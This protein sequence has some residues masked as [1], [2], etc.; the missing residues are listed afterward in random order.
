MKIHGLCLVKNE[1]DVLQETL[2]SALH[3]CDHIYVF[4][5]GSNDGT[6]EL[7]KEHCQD[8]IGRLCH[9]CRM[10]SYIAMVSGLIFSMHFGRTLALK[11]G[12]A[13]W[14]QMNSILMTQE[15]FLLK[16]PDHFQTVWSA[17]LN[18]YFTD[19]DVI[20]V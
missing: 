18:Y 7:V 3:W 4:D 5:N 11:I 6:W 16:F 9:T 17:S 14:T 20:H 2:L 8:S 1:A 10:T 19:Q 15:F 12:G 13:R